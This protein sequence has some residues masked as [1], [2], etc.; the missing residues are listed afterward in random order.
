MID[1]NYQRRLIMG[2]NQ[3]ALKIGI[4]GFLTCL[5]ILPGYGFSQSPF[6]QDKTI[7]VIQG[8][9]PG[10][11]GD[12]RRKA[13]F[14]FLQKY[15]PGNPTIVSNYMPGG[16]DRKAANYTYR[17]RPDGLTIGGLSSSM[18]IN[19]IL[20][21]SG[22]QYDIDKW[23][24]L[25]SPISFFH[26]V[27]LTRKEAGLNSLEKLRSVPSVRIGGQEVGHDSYVVARLFAYAIGMKETKWVTGYGGPE[28][29]VALMR[30]EVDARA[31]P[32]ESVIQRNPDWLEKGLMD[33]HAII[34]IPK[35]KKLARFARLPE[36]ED[37]VGSEKDRKLL[38]M[39]RAFRLVGTPYILPPGTS[40]AQIQIL[41]EAFRKAFNDP[42]FQNEF[43]RL[44]GFDA[45]PLMP[46]AM[47]RVIKEIPRE[48][49]IVDLFK[50]LSGPEP[51]PPH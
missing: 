41:R 42:G 17:A 22:V 14:P 44:A 3:A 26:Y 32:P 21:A 45:S 1:L 2:S 13:L 31:T 29:D 18:V 34:E 46:E 25:G 12:M 47:E 19:A 11:T 10:G 37:F 5:F 43:K 27:F 39:Y 36:I 48:A 7:T 50:K 20:G 9:G 4:L 51:L 8:V 35:G 38:A 33:F 30:G 15:I 23:I 49:E 16:G 24:Y 40:T 6:Y 28:M